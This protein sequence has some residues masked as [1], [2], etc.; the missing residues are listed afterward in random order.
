MKHILL[1]FFFLSTAFST[2]VDLKPAENVVITSNKNKTQVQT[3]AHGAPYGGFLHIGDRSY[4]TVRNTI[5]TRR[6]VYQ[7]IG[8]SGVQVSM[9]SYGISVNR[10]T[11]FEI[12]IE[13][14]LK[15]YL[16]FSQTLFHQIIR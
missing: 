12:S 5:L 4:V 2:S 3:N 13:R 6:K 11:S 15:F 9:G 16:G 14:L 7:S 1:C 10:P 8:S